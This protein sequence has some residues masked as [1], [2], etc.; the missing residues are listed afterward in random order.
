MQVPALGECGA[1]TDAVPIWNHTQERFIVDAAGIGI[2]IGSV[3]K[4][5]AILVEGK[6]DTRAIADG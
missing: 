2:G 4:S 3:W 1:I 5:V 6:P